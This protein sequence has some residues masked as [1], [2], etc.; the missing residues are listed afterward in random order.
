MDEEKSALLALSLTRGI[1]AVRIH[2]GIREAG[3]AARLI[4]MKAGRLRKLGFGSEACLSLASGESERKAEAASGAARA[5]GYRIIGFNE[6]GYP[7]LLREIYDPPLILYAAGDPGILETPSLSVVGARRCTVYG[8]QVTFLMAREFAEIG[9]CVVSGMARGIDARAHLGALAARGPTVAVLGTGVDIAY[10]RENRELYRKIREGGCLLSEFP[11]GSCPAPQNFPVRNRIISGLS[12]GTLITEAAEF[13]G[14]LI[15]ARLALEQDREL[16]AVPGN[17]TSRTSYG[18]NYLIKQGAHPLLNPAE[19]VDHL[20]PHVLRRLKSPP[21]TGR[22]PE[23][24]PDALSPDEAQLVNLLT[25]DRLTGIDRLLAESGFSWPRLS[26]ML[27]QLEKKEYI[28]RMPG[29]RYCRNLRPEDLVY[30]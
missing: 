21:E 24:G 25:P 20:P 2:R 10:P 4:R 7:G 1:G 29:N 28:K 30:D 8:E 5:G 14:S 6:S 16:W 19:I 11:L 13:S 27:L 26:E 12:W 9:L 17:I 22:Q 15:T 3:S 18:P 23:A